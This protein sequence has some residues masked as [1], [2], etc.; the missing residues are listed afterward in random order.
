MT[1]DSCKG[2]QMFSIFSQIFI[3]NVFN[4]SQHAVWDCLVSLAHNLAG[5]FFCVCVCV[6]CGG[7]G[8]LQARRWTLSVFKETLA[9]LW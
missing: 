2:D 7:G 3:F 5:E 1:P 6:C 4:S 8:G 9:S